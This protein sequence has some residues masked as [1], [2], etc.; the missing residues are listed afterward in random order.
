[1]QRRYDQEDHCEYVCNDATSQQFSLGDQRSSEALHSCVECRDYMHFYCL[2]SSFEAFHCQCYTETA[3]G[4]KESYNF[5]RCSS[6]LDYG[7]YGGRRT[8]FPLPQ[9][10]ES[11]RCPFLLLFGLNLSLV[12]STTFMLPSRLVPRRPFLPF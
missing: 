1:M 12:Q 4:L 10:R 7:V 11:H 8:T 3:L 2:Q 5:S 6:S 9:V